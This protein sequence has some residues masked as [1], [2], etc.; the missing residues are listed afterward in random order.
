M[1]KTETYRSGAIH[2]PAIRRIEEALQEIRAGGLILVRDDEGRENEGD[3]LCAA[4]HATPENIAF[5]A[6]HGRGLIC[7]PVTAERARRLNLEPMAPVNTESHGTAFTVSVDAATGI[8]TGISAADR[9]HTIAVTIAAETVP[10]DL[11]RP[12]HVFPLVARE[13]GVLARKGHTEAAVDLAR[14]AGL[15]PSGVICEVL[16]DDGSMARGPELEEMARRHGLPLVSVADLIAYRDA[17][18]DIPLERSTPARMATSFGEFLATAYRTGD[19]VTPEVLLLEHRGTDGEGGP[20]TAPATVPVVRV[21]SECLTGE[22]LHSLRCDCGAQLDESMRTV[23]SEG[24]AIVYLRQ[25][26]RG[27]GLFEK[28]RAYTLQDQGLDTVDANL[29]LGHAVDLRRFGAA[30][31]I[32]RERGYRE[33][34]LM[35]NNPDKID[36]LQAGGITVRERIP[37]HVGHTHQNRGYRAA[38]SAR[39]GHLG[40]NNSQRK[41]N[42][43]I[44]DN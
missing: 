37:L 13:G 31:A 15:I 44:Q 8:T 3:L 17:A 16:N 35:T 6:V 41:E 9:A 38:K 25:E 34:R 12:G 36:A 28:I 19:P 29:A 21:H 26:G 20:A 14:L 22:A 43:D 18:G 24:G 39:L 4:E 42:Y 11:R 32:L 7:Q 2:A 10:D 23:A 30:A 1:T 33:V 5:M 40:D 27:I